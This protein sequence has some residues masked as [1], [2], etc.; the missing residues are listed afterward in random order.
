M[1]LAIRVI[2]GYD[3]KNI[4]IGQKK[5]AYAHLH[6]LT[7]VKV[8]VQW[9][10][11]IGKAE[12]DFNVVASMG[13]IVPP[14]KIFWGTRDNLVNIEALT[15]SLPDGTWNLPVSGYEHIDLLWG[16][17]APEIFQII[18]DQLCEGN[19]VASQSAIS[20]TRPHS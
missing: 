10:Q 16:D 11:I 9:L 17:R 20:T 18:L 1:D 14:I 3:S 8:V 12:F 2:F 7:S 19:T 5:A 6:S 15:K 13:K 4:S